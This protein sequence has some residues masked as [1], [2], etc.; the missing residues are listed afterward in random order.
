MKTALSFYLT[1]ATS[2]YN[3]CAVHCLTLIIRV[4]SSLYSFRH[5][6]KTSSSSHFL[7]RH[8]P[9]SLKV[10]AAYLYIINNASPPFKTQRAILNQYLLY[11][12]SSP[13][14]FSKRRSGDGETS[15]RKKRRMEQR[16]V[17]MEEGKNRK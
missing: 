4:P 9:F 14:E 12:S 1:K 8:K 3:I 11:S 10:A 17:S 5:G 6:K 16:E 2:S 13:P 15:G 7:P